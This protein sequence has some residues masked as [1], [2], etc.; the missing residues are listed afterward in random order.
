[1]SALCPV[2]LDIPPT[3]NPVAYIHDASWFL[4]HCR[5]GGALAA[6]NLVIGVCKLYPVHIPMFCNNSHQIEVY[7]A[8][9]VLQSRA[10][11]VL[12]YHNATWTFY[13]S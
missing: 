9:V 11:S 8:C 6:L 3:G 7:V 5:S 13:D 2:V 1:M 4:G 10:P 12:A